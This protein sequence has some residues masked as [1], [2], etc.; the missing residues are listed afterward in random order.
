[1]GPLPL[2][3]GKNSWPLLMCSQYVLQRRRKLFSIG[4]AGYGGRSRNLHAGWGHPSCPARGY[5]EAL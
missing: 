5:G 3:I 1:M 2:S 4:P